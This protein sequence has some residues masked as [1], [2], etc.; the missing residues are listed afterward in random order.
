MEAIILQEEKNKEK[1]SEIDSKGKSSIY[2]PNSLS[3]LKEITIS[4][5]KSKSIDSPNTKNQNKFFSQT[6][7]S[8]IKQNLRETIRKSIRIPNKVIN[9]VKFSNS[10]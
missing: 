2:I 7:E 9:V 6:R 3:P 8:I 10:Y 1:E 5:D 4:R